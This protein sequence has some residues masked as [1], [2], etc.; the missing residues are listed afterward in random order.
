[1]Y[2]QSETCVGRLMDRDAAIDTLKNASS[3]GC[4]FEDGVVETALRVLNLFPRRTQI[5]KITG[6][7][8]GDRGWYSTLGVDIADGIGIVVTK[9]RIQVS[10]GRMYCYEADCMEPANIPVD[11]AVAIALLGGVE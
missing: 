10:L 9:N 6:H 2:Q 8:P 4:F 1:M 7:L 11:L 5:S 3:T